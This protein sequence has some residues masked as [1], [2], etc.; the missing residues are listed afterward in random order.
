MGTRWR[1]SAA[2]TVAVLIGMLVPPSARADVGL[3]PG[4][5]LNIG[6]HQCSLGFLATNDDSDRLAVTAGHCADDVDQRV[7][8][9]NGNLIGSVVHHA[10]NNLTTTLSA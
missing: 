1:G 6:D 2:A 5:E 4:T 9:H 7:Y 8:S 3:A 10:P